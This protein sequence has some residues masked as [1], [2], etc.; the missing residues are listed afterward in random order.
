MKRL[1]ALLF[2][3][4]IFIGLVGMMGVSLMNQEVYGRWGTVVHRADSPTRYWA[5]IGLLVGMAVLLVFMAVRVWR[6]E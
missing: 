6:D 3:A 2:L 1:L 4:L 5:S